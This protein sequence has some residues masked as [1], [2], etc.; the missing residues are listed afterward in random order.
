MALVAPSAALGAGS[1]LAQQREHI[2]AVH[3]ELQPSAG[4]S[5]RVPREGGAPGSTN[6]H[7]HG[8]RSLAGGSSMQSYSVTGGML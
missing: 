4:P 8:G 6:H 1:W 5:A 7:G 2:S 3:S